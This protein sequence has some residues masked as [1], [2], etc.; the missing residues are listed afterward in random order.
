M[1][2]LLFAMFWFTSCT[3]PS[4]DFFSFLISMILTPYFFW[5][6]SSFRVFPTMFIG[7][8]FSSLAAAAERLPGTM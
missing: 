1:V 7:S 3:S 4:L 5:M 2:L 6:L 8:P